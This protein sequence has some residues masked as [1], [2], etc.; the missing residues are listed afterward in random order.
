MPFQS[1]A[2]G[3]FGPQSLRTLRGPAAPVW[4]SSGTLDAS[5]PQAQA[6]SRQLVA[7]DDSGVAPTYSLVSGSLPSGTTLSSSGLIS[8]TPNAAGTY[9]FV[10]R[11]T[12][13]NGQST[14]SGTL[15]VIVQASI[16]TPQIWYKN[17]RVGQNPVINDGTWGSSYNASFTGSTTTDSGRNVWHLGTGY[18]EHPFFNVLPSTSWGNGFTLTAVFRV[19]GGA[20]K[21]SLM[22]S[23]TGSSQVVGTRSA[24]SNYQMIIW[25]ND[26][27]PGSDPWHQGT[28]II[29]NMVQTTYRVQSNGR[30]QIFTPNR[31]NGAVY[32]VTHPAY[33]SQLD[34]QRIGWSRGS[35]DSTWYLVEWMFWNYPLSDSEVQQVRNYIGTTHPIGVVNN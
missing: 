12:D 32:D 30:C 24:A 7:T 5:V 3:K 21:Y 34:T 11:A 31:T 33:S 28:D 8:G 23:P 27:Y 17:S 25:N 29:N 15:T 19:A 4:V 22:G 6:Y 20:I 16:P 9:N 10:V 2:R 1:S 26:G 35:Q 13:E 14:N 18:L